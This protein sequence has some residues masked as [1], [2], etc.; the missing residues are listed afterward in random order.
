MS[1]NEVNEVLKERKALAKDALNDN[2][3]LPQQVRDEIAKG[4]KS[5]DELLGEK[6]AP[7]H[8]FEGIVTPEQREEFRAWLE[9]IQ[10]NPE[11]PLNADGMHIDSGKDEM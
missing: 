3:E 5:S 11:S 2:Q 1:F 10:S 7:N 8:D 4:L 9:N 6:Y